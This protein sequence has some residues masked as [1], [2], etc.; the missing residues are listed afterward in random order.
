VLV[1]HT[2]VAG[3]TG[4]RDALL[5]GWSDEFKLLEGHGTIGLRAVGK[6]RTT[7]DNGPYVRFWHRMDPSLALGRSVVAGA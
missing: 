4:Q 6:R 1:G 3:D 7:S 5:Q 2:S